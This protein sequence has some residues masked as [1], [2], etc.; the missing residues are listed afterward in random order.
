MY[1]S[2]ATVTSKGQISLPKKVRDIIGTNIVS[3]EINEK[4]QVVLMP[5]HDLAGSLSEC[6]NILDIP[7]EEMRQQAWLENS[8][9]I[10]DSKL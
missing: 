4:Q 8:K 6:K 10:K 9:Y 1:I 3:I 2:T 5:I 7:F